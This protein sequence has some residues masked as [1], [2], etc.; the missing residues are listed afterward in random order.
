VSE[1]SLTVNGVQRRAVVEDRTSLVDLLRDVLGLT[2]THVGC[3]QGACGA[4]T[5]LV[6][7]EPVRSCLFL[8]VQAERTRVETVESLGTQHGLGVVQQAMRECHAFQ[9][10]FCAPGI[11][12]TVVALLRERA[13]PSPFEV[14]EWL[15]GNLCRCTGYESIVAGTMLAA[16]R[17]ASERTA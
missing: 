9:C 5:V 6:D 8:A 4:C 13:Q 12:M 11:L 14:R 1:V 2:G 10:G 3:E 15:S 7:G 16:A 17:L